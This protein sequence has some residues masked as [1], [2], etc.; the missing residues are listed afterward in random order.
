DL[1]AEWRPSAGLRPASRERREGLRSGTFVSVL[2]TS[3]ARRAVSIPAAALQQR[4]ALASVFVVGRDGIARLRLV[5][6][7]DAVADRV[8]ILS[9]LDAGETIVTALGG[10]RDGVFVRVVRP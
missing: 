7:G 6:A 1:P 5:T 4:G 8:E 2:F 3:G 10:V 9:G